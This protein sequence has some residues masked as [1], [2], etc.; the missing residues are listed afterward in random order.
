M[1]PL[2][3]ELSI[4]APTSLNQTNAAQSSPLMMTQYYEEDDDEKAVD[5]YIFKEE[6][7]ID[8]DRDEKREREI[9]R[10]CRRSKLRE[11][12][13]RGRRERGPEKGEIEIDR[14]IGKRT[15]RETI[16]GREM[17]RDRATSERIELAQR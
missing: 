8:R 2:N 4:V 7:S 11:E 17:S 16:A 6:S 13:E 5:N 3:L 10:N 15:E 1:E 9:G 14:E 12:R